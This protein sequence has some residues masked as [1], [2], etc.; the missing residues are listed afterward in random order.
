LY[1]TL[2]KTK[3]NES[4]RWEQIKPEH[5]RYLEKLMLS[6]ERNG[7]GLPSEKK[8]KVK[9]LQKQIADLERVA[10]KNINEDKTKVEVSEEDLE[11][12]PKDMINNL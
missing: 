4:A 6:M 9:E 5:R 8:E 1:D 3:E 10:Q 11:G 7:L 2:K 12:L